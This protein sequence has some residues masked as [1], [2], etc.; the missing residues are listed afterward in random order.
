[1]KKTTKRYPYQRATKAQRQVGAW[2]WCIH[3]AVKAERLSEPVAVRVA[4]IRAH[5]PAHEHE[6]RLRA[7]RPVRD[8]AAVATARQAYHA[9]FASARQAYHAAVAPAQQAYDAAV[10]TA[11]ARECADVPWDDRMGLIFT[12]AKAKKRTRKARRK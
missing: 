7:L 11:W 12:V 4:Y 10:A 3:H 5:K 6:A 1:M 2:W 8:V 9:A